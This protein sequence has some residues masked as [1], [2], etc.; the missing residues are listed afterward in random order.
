MY[1]GTAFLFIE[2]QVSKKKHLLELIK[3]KSKVYGKNKER[4]FS[5]DQLKAF[6][7]NYKS[8]RVWLWLVYN[9]TEDN[10]CLCLFTEFIQTQNRYLA[11][12][13]KTSILTWRLLVISGRIW[14]SHNI[15]NGAIITK[16]SILD[17]AAVLSPPLHITPK[18]V[19]WIK[20]LDNLLF[21][22]YLKY[23]MIHW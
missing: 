16:R 17:V 11:S 8:M 22:K 12:L 19:Y 15:Q 3:R 14:D 6:S 5:F 7:E 18:N 20:L 21:A 10:R 1:L 9:I 23:F 2:N 4:T 13:E